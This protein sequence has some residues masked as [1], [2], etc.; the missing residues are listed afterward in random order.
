VAGLPPGAVVSRLRE[1][2]IVATETPYNPSYARVGPGILNTP[3]EV[4]RAL[5]AIRAL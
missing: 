1:R 4:R 5:A 2:R 3:A